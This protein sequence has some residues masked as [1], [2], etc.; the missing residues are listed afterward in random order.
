MILK[1]LKSNYLVLGYNMLS[2][3]GKNIRKTQ[4]FDFIPEDGTAEELYDI[5]TD[6]KSI[7]VSNPTDVRQNLLY[8]LIEA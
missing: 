1:A 2:I 5:A 8:D 4:K 3:E 7:L 6:I